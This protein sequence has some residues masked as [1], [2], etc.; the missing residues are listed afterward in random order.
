MQQCTSTQMRHLQTPSIPHKIRRTVHQWWPC[1]KPGT[2]KAQAWET[3]PSIMQASQLQAI[4]SSIV[5]YALHTHT[6]NPHTYQLLNEAT[7]DLIIRRSDVNLE[8]LLPKNF[9]CLANCSHR[10]SC[11]TAPNLFHGKSRGLSAMV[12]PPQMH[13]VQGIIVPGAVAKPPHRRE[14]LLL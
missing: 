14:Y 2:W 5:A 1:E 8:A 4:M 13:I 10:C 9:N 7:R 11:A 6:G 3:R 12:E